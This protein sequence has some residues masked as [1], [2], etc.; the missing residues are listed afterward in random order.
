MRF[1]PKTEKEIAEANLWPTGNY[2]FEIMEAEDTLS[3]AGNEMMEMKVRLYSEDCGTQIVTDYLVDTPKAAFKIRHCANAVGL[4]AEYEK[5]ELLAADLVRRTGKCKV[6]IRKDN[7]G[8]YP[9][10]NQIA[11]YL[12]SDTGRA[13]ELPPKEKA[14]AEIDDE[15]PF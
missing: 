10:K 11:D 12:K 1:A 13:V 14:N 5:G 8:Q 15:I 3:K 9:D 2:D 7:S 6:V 4:L